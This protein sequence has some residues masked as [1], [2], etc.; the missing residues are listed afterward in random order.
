MNLLNSN[1]LPFLI[2]VCL[3]IYLGNKSVRF[4]VN[5]MIDKYIFKKEPKKQI[6]KDNDLDHD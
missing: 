5:T 3:G 1:Y 6:K 4:K 2:G